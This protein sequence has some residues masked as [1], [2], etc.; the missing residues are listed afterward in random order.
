VNLKHENRPDI[1]RQA[2]QLLEAENQRLHARIGAMARELATLKGLGAAGVQHELFKL[3]ELLAQREKALFAAS[4][5]KRTHPDKTAAQANKE[6]GKK[7]QTG[8][9]PKEQPALR[10][11]PRLF[12]LDDADKICPDCGGDLVEMVGQDE[13]TE[14]IDVLRREF[15]LVKNQCKKYRCSCGNCIQTAKGSKKLKPGM[16][17]SIDFAIAV[18][19]DKYS[20][21][22]PLDR[23]VRMMRGEGL[24]V[25][26]QTLWDQ[27]EALAS[28]LKGIPERIRQ[29]LLTLSVLGADET[30]WPLLDK[31]DKPSKRKVWYAWSLCTPLAVYYR[32]S[33]KRN[34]KEV[35]DLLEAFDG[36]LMTDG[37]KIY[38]SAK[39]KQGCKYISA[40]CW[41]HTRRKFLA[42]E[43]S[44]SKEAGAIINLI[45]EL[46]AIDRLADKRCPTGPPNDSEKLETLRKLRHER[47]KPVLQALAAWAMMLKV[48]PDT[49]MGRALSYMTD[50]WTG[51][52]RF[53]SDPGIPLS[54]NGTERALRGPVVGRKNHYGS[55]SRRGTE[56]AALFY[57]LIES[58]LLAGINPTAYLRR[59]VDDALDGKVPPL[60]H[61]LAIS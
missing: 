43:A 37:L 2:A 10:T 4:S 55:K 31:R 1:L 17:Y 12:D 23:Q 38:Q 60:P 59:A 61:E 27:I 8:H 6:K 21:H 48:L 16:R 47:S 52:I 18:A 30:E 32:V 14:E 42:A 3:R 22:L 24:D 56:V 20:F 53:A 58:A 25:T 35:C 29:Y 46:F 19:L 11:V 39:T 50:L 51:L 41:A 26:S 45:D 49:A 54:N 9:G 36:V 57:T 5:E 33:E 40:F 7:P 44:H 34:S 15:V 13:V 28:L